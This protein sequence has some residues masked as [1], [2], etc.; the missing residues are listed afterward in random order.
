MKA[1]RCEVPKIPKGTFHSCN[2]ENDLMRFGDEGDVFVPIPEKIA[3][4]PR[5]FMSFLGFDDVSDQE[6]EEALMRYGVAK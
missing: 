2:N 4:D 5:R 3:T 6:I 1:F